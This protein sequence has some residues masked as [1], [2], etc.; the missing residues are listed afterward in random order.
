LKSESHEN[1]FPLGNDSEPSISSDIASEVQRAFKYQNVAGVML[2]CGALKFSSHVEFWFERQEDILG[3]RTDGLIDFYQ[4]KTKANSSRWKTRDK[5]IIKSLSRFGDIEQKLST[6]VHRYYIYSNIPPYIPSE[7]AIQES[8]KS[9]S[10][11]GLQKF[12]LGQLIPSTPAYY[13]DELDRLGRST[14]MPLE[15]L[16]A[17]LKKLEFIKGQSLEGF[18]EELSSTLCTLPK[19]DMLP[20]AKLR[21]LGLDILALVEGAGSLNLPALD[22]L[23]S[24]VSAKGVPSR[25]LANKRVTLV[26]TQ[27][28]IDAFIRKESRKKQMMLLAALNIALLL[29]AGT[30]WYC[31]KPESESY[32]EKSA[33]IVFSARSAPLPP[34]FAESISAVRSAKLVLDN[35]D[36]TGASLRCQDMSRLNL[37]R[38]TAE[39]LRGTGVVFNRSNLYMANLSHSELNSSSYVSAKGDNAVFDGSNLLASDFS[40]SIARWT[41]FKTAGMTASDFSN[42]D[43]SQADFSNAKLEFSEFKGTNLSGANFNGADITSANMSSANLIG[44][45]GLTQ[46]MLDKACVE[47]ALHP[48]L[49]REL[50]PPTTQCYAD[51]ESK[52]Q[53]LASQQ[54]TALI[55]QMVALGGYCKDGE[56]IVRPPD[57]H[58]DPELE[59]PFYVPLKPQD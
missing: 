3:V 43:L 4:V 54:V 38:L 48:K 2:L 59:L 6:K 5:E 49:D 11:L 20:L 30:A 55:G 7:E 27:K 32:L 42:A 51:D 39:W 46:E 12:L 33:K 34:S 31:Y 29:V 50:R 18:R 56:V 23:T 15:R 21:V 47:G 40:G 22:T 52:A 53:R 58:G 16:V 17:V 36:L 19:L 35:I 41:S 25:L 57:G 14:D 10:L 26:S 1:S 45:R 9:T 8:R 37:S 13:H 28:L 24:M 44:A